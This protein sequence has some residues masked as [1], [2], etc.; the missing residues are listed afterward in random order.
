MYQSEVEE[1][2]HF[3]LI[4]QKLFQYRDDMT[5]VAENKRPN[6]VVHLMKE[7]KVH[8]LLTNENPEIYSILAKTVFKMSKERENLTQNRNMTSTP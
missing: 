2:R 6:F 4:C 1:V 8:H 7:Q 3:L 5:N